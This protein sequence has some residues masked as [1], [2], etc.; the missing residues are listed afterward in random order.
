M[1]VFENNTAQPSAIVNF[2]CSRASALP[3]IASWACSTFHD[4]VPLRMKCST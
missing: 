2:E 4:A 1:A 3:L